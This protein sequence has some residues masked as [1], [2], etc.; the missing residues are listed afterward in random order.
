MVCYTNCLYCLL[1]ITDLDQPRIN[2]TDTRPV[3]GTGVTI[4]CIVDGE[5]PPTVRWIM[6]GSLLNTSGNSRI[7]FTNNNEQLII[8]NVNRADSGEYLCVAQNS[9]GNVSSNVSTLS[10]QCKKMICPFGSCFS[11]YHEI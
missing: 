3:E 2:S 10:V 8:T 7:S 5:P 11:E 9:R 6:S 4:S 1:I